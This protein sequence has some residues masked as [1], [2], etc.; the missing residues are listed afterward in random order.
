MNQEEPYEFEVPVKKSK[1]FLYT[2]IAF[3]AAVISYVV[4][5]EEPSSGWPQNVIHLLIRH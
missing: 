2:F 4:L 3:I 1:L 5:V